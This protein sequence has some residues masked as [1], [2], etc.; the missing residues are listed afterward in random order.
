MKNTMNTSGSEEAMGKAARDKQAVEKRSGRAGIAA[1]DR[2]RTD[3][4]NTRQ[5]T[6]SAAD[7]KT[8]SHSHPFN[9]LKDARGERMLAAELKE[10]LGL[11]VRRVRNHA[12][13]ADKADKAYKSA[14]TGMPGWSVACKNCATSALPALPA[15]WRQAVLQAQDGEIPVLFYKLPRKPFRAV[16]HASLFLGGH[17]DSDPDY[18]LDMSLLCFAA[19]YREWQAIDLAAEQ[20]QRDRYLMRGGRM[21]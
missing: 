12:G 21:Q 16:V 8:G 3:S 11:D 19:L 14:L 15:W 1:G 5:S 10:L 18:I 4:A 2:T 20:R 7:R 17:T 13:K 9:S 6:Q